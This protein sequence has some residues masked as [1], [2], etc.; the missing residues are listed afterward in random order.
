MGFNHR[1][2][3]KNSQVLSKALG[4]TSRV[5]FSEFTIISSF[6]NLIVS[7]HKQNVCLETVLSS[8][9]SH[10]AGETWSVLSALLALL[11]PAKI[12]HIQNVYIL[13]GG[14]CSLN[15]WREL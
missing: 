3:N 7:A 8:G 12:K 11:L 4:K 1:S 2:G 6:E 13:D 9:W 5:R 15:I 14:V 10:D